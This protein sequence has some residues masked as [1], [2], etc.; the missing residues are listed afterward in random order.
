MCILSY[1]MNCKTAS[2]VYTKLCNVFAT[3]VNKPQK[4]KLS[5]EFL[6]V[7]Y[8][9]DPCISA[10]MSKIENLAH[11]FK[12]VN[13]NVSDDMIITKILTTLPEVYRHFISAGESTKKK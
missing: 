9:K 5:Q 10:H 8:E 13:E 12:S 7:V 11:K 2:E 6:N 1:I 4:N 3:K